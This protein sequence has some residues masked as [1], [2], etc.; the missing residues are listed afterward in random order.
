MNIIN[1][2]IIIIIVNWNKKDDL[3]RCLGRLTHIN[4]QGPLDILVIDNASTDGSVEMLKKEFPSVKVIVNRENIGG[5]GGFNKG[6]QSALEMGYSYLWL[7]DNDAIAGRN[8]LKNALKVIEDDPKVGMV[9]AQILD[10]EKPFQTVE[11]GAFINWRYEGTIP[12]FRRFK[13]IKPGKIFV[14]DYVP[15]CCAL[16]RG[17]AIKKIRGIDPN[18]FLHWD[19][20]DLGWRMT[21]SG[22]KVVVPTNAL[23]FHKQYDTP[24]SYRV[25]YYN[26]RN[27]LYF[28]AKHLKGLKRFFMLW[29]IVLKRYLLMISRFFM[30]D[31]LEASIAYKA[32]KDFY[33]GQLGRI[34]YAL[35]GQVITNKPP[36]KILIAHHFLGIEKQQ[37]MNKTKQNFPSAN[38]FVV[39][40]ADEASSFPKSSY[41]PLPS[42]WKRISFYFQLKKMNFDLVINNPNIV[43]FYEIFLPNC[44]FWQGN[45]LYYKKISLGRIIGFVSII[46]REFIKKSIK[47]SLLP[48][49]IITG[50][51]FLPKYRQILKWIKK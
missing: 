35:P 43:T 20:M 3:R 1:K 16:I 21:R 13:R 22:Y 26:F 7:L 30:G 29:Q 31:R 2:K 19:D 5:A 24:P 17:E 12:N 38:V 47:F 34:Q 45:Q 25:L 9:G 37:L 42:R 46:S 50:L 36:Q 4:Y 11:L 40:L 18:Y 39:G 44:C 32:L 33:K 23:A 27:P 10:I 14:V 48:L 6:I 8:F 49:G 41:F 51:V 15:I 28:Y